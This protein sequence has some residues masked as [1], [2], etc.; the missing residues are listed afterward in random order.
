MPDLTQI[1]VNLTNGTMTARSLG[2]GIV[3]IELSDDLGGRAKCTATQGQ[4]VEAED[5][6]RVSA[7]NAQ[8]P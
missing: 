3:E 1:P 2:G 8:Q 5:A 6:I 7:S 4:C